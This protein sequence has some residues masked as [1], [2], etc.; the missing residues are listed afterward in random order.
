MAFLAATLWTLG[1]TL[2]LDLLRLAF[3]RDLV[4]SVACQAAAYLLI[5]FLILRLHAPDARLQSF[6]A[7]RRAH[8]AFYPI[9]AALGAALFVVAEA[10]Y[11]LVQRR[12]PETGDDD[13]AF[14][15]LLHGPLP[16]RIAVGV[17]IIAV[18]PALEEVLF[19]GALFRPLE[20]RY[21]DARSIVVGMTAALFA[22]AHLNW[23]ATAHLF[24][25]GCAL[26][27]LRQASGSIGPTLLAHA[28][29]NAIPFFIILLDRSGPEASAGQTLPR[30]LIAAG[31]ASLLALLGLVYLVS[32]RTGAEGDAEEAKHP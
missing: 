22:V 5:V 26:G 11:E 20:R 17:V 27:F 12:Y 3:A 25:A 29:Y 28:T 19:R 14:Y 6:L 24:V 32:T 10:V 15:K 16:Q 13:A 21:A 30:W 2:V 4:G 18:S 8:L 31:A 9:A 1:A 7:I 23:Q